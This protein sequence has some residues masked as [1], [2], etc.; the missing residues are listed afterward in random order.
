M[1]GPV[2]DKFIKSRLPRHRS[3]GG[4]VFEKQACG[5]DH[6]PADFEIRGAPRL[7]ASLAAYIFWS[8]SVSIWSRFLPSFHSAIPMLRVSSKLPRCPEAFQSCTD[9]A[10]RELT[11]PAPSAGLSARKTR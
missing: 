2:R 11:I 9:L 5:G 7:R 3:L 1:V 10:T 6:M 8:A 4:R